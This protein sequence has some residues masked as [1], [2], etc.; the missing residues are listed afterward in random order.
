M[1][2]E[3]IPQRANVGVELALLLRREHDGARRVAHGHDEAVVW[4]ERPLGEEPT[5]L[6]DPVPRI[7]CMRYPL[8]L[9]CRLALHML[10]FAPVAALASAHLEI[11]ALFPRVER[12]RLRVWA[13]GRVGRGHRHRR[14]Q[15]TT[16]HETER[17]EPHLLLVL[18][19]T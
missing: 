17:L 15:C 18:L 5:G 2:R 1:R 11:V 14:T 10:V 19:Y 16:G 4:H 6:R 3:A 7:L 12:C 9:R 13:V 8:T